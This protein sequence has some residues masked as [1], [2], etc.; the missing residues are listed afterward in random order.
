LQT[1]P[2][3]VSVQV[4]PAFVGSFETEAVKFRVP[5]MATLIVAG[6]T[7][8][9]IAGTAIVA[10]PV[11]A[12]FV[13]VVAVNVIAQLTLGLAG[14]VY[15]IGAPLRVVAGE[16]EPALQGAGEPLIDQFTPARAGSLATV[17]AKVVVCASSTVLVPG[18]TDTVM[19]W[20]APTAAANFVASV[21]E[22]AVMVTDRSLAGGVGGAV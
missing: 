22:V 9:E 16:T 21:T 2:F 12:A 3:C 14:A 13:T 1:L 18:A 10:V 11:F 20:T 6:E 8:T 4:A 15:V 19:A 7:E 5:L 17:A